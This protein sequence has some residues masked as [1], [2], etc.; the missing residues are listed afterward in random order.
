MEQ[1]EWLTSFWGE[2]ENNRKVKFYCQT[3]TGK[4]QLDVEREQ[5]KRVAWAMG[6]ALRKTGSPV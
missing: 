1:A 4:K 2:S 5:W 6:P 3:K